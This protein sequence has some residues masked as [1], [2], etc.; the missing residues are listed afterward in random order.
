M[1][2]RVNPLRLEDSL[3]LELLLLDW[4]HF[5]RRIP[6]SSF[7][8]SRLIDSI[9]PFQCK[10]F[11][12]VAW[13]SYLFVFSLNSCIF[14]EA[15]TKML[16]EGK[17]KVILLILVFILFNFLFGSHLGGNSDVSMLCQYYHQDFT[18]P[19][20]DEQRRCHKCFAKE[21]KTVSFRCIV[22]LLGCSV[23]NFAVDRWAVPTLK[24]HLCK[25]IGDQKNPVLWTFD[26]TFTS[27]TYPSHLSFHLQKIKYGM[28]P[29]RCL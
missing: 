23:L 25:V 6:V 27:T 16:A 24:E 3:Q 12:I 4:T 1:P 28:C 11:W 19:L 15:K 22:C 8:L 14:F 7:H 13:L 9:R 5:A 20:T 2:W 29:D 17:W 18:E 21:N 26:I 10:S